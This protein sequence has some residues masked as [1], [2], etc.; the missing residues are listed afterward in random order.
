MCYNQQ[1]DGMLIPAQQKRRE[2]TKNIQLEPTGQVKRVKTA[3][4][5]S[6]TSKRLLAVAA[7]WRC[8]M[9]RDPAQ[10]ACC[11]ESAMQRWLVLAAWCKLPHHCCL[12]H[13]SFS[14][15]ARAFFRRTLVRASVTLL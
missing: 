6:A 2:A 3:Q 15:E 13:S 8:A 12:N 4:S 14:R 10:H 5:R 11:L 1:L 7:Y 9:N